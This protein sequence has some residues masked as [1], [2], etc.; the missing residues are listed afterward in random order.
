MLCVCDL[1]PSSLPHI[2]PLEIHGH[3]PRRQ[4]HGLDQAKKPTNIIHRS[5]LAKHGRKIAPD[6]HVKPIAR[7]DMDMEELHNEVHAR[8]VAQQRRAGEPQRAVLHFLFQVPR[9]DKVDHLPPTAEHPE[10]IH[11]LRRQHWHESMP[12]LGQSHRVLEATLK[13]LS[14]QDDGD[15]DVCGDFRLDAVRLHSLEAQQHRIHIHCIST[16]PRACD[17]PVRR[18]KCVVQIHSWL[19]TQESNNVQNAFAVLWTVSQ[20]GLHQPRQRLA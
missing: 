1:P 20:L 2:E 12:I 16:C 8:L 15:R 18:N 7:I 6:L 10:L 5:R 14:K 4:I 11:N 3:R 9:L 13:V 19:P 17:A